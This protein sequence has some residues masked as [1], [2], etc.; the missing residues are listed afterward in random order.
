MALTFEKLPVALGAITSSIKLTRFVGLVPRF[1]GIGLDPVTPFDFVYGS[2]STASAAAVDFWLEL[3]GTGITP[4]LPPAG[5]DKEWV[6]VDTVSLPAVSTA[7]SG[8]SGVGTAGQIY[9]L[10]QRVST[11]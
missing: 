5:V 1:V 9:V 6:R 3:A 4:T 11:A 8:V 7:N 10:W 2:E